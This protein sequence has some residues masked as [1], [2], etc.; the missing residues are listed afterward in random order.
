[1]VPETAFLTLRSDGYDKYAQADGRI[2]GRPGVDTGVTPDGPALRGAT[3]LV[4]GHLDHREVAFHPRAFREIYRFIAAEEPR[5]IAVAPQAR[6]TLDG[7]VTGNP[8]GVPNN[9][10]VAGAAVEVYRVDPVKGDRQGQAL[11]RRTTGPDGRW[12]P[13][14]VAPTDW[15]EFVVT[16]PNQATTHLYRSPFP[17]SSDVVHLRPARPLAEADKAAGA[18]VQMVRPRGY[19]GLPRDIVLF[20]GKEPTD[21]ARGVPTDSATMVKLPI[22][23]IGRPVAGMFNEERIVARAWPAA[24]NRLTVAELTW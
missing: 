23:E 8:G 18:I 3:N 11:L 19:F 21:I 14:T 2:L 6:V 5:I 16:A 20:D 10:P 1:V 17:R 7:L 12:G 4:I 22:G 9:R 15:L 24:E 13:V